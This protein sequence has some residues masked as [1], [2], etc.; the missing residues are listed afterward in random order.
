M[1]CGKYKRV[2]SKDVGEPGGHYIK[3]GVREKPGPR[4][5]VTEIIGGL[6][7]YKKKR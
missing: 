6:R 2:R 7:T 1:P 3:I 5:G 4:G